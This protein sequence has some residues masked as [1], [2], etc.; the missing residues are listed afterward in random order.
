MV[1]DQNKSYLRFFEEICAIP[2]GSGNE[3]QLSDFLMEFA[4]SRGLWAWQD[5]WWNVII[6]K[7]AAPGCEKAAP[8]LLQ[9]H[10]DMVC[11]KRTD[12]THDFLCDGLN[13]AVEDGW[14]H[15]QG[16]T[17]GADD[18]YAV[19]TMLALLE[20]ETLKAPALECV[21]TTQEETTMA[22]AAGLDYSLL[23]ARRM[24]GLDEAGETQTCV[25][26]AGSMSVKAVLP[27]TW[28]EDDRAHVRFTVRGLCGGHSGLMIDKG[29]GNAVCL[30]ARLFTRILGQDSRVRLTGI[31]GG[32]AENAIPHEC[33]VGFT[34]DETFVPHAEQIL[35][36]LARNIAW[37]LRQ[38]D[39]GFCLDVAQVQGRGKSL[40]ETATRA[41][42]D[43]LRL[44]P[45][46][47]AAMSFAVPG[48]VQT[49]VNLGKVDLDEEG[50][51]LY[52]LLRSVT[53]SQMDEL[54]ERIAGLFR[55]CG[56]KHTVGKRFP[57]REMLL[58][59]P[60]REALRVLMREQWGEELVELAA[61]G[62][63]EG[64]YFSSRLPGLD[65]I[66][67]GP[68]MEGVHSPEEKMSLASFDK[69]YH[70]LRLLLE[71]LTD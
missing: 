37:E 15:A 32:A 57:G 63:G 16:T 19:A 45:N 7:P 17:L 36:E 71:R 58:V 22:G 35:R 5:E 39:P 20:D 28:E 47:V 6:K 52:C 33:T 30:A 44:F 31:T 26:T 10:M 62:G 56:A 9:G 67:L 12:S 64:G 38:T 3:K 4:R 51:I 27:L 23:T 25:S 66:T 65:I 11:E 55:M 41:V 53:D 24:I 14:V 60:L 21:F 54:F 68:L 40:T 50:L 48:L 42:A 69:V 49:S 61:H 8:V 2:H 34:C 70:L 18:G 46:G 43:M 13:L 59:S 29:R 1:L